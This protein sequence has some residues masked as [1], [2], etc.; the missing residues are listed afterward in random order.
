MGSVGWTSGQR[1]SRRMSS[2]GRRPAPVGGDAHPRV[3]VA[4]RGGAASRW[5]GPRWTSG[6]GCRRHLGGYG[7]WRATPSLLAGPVCAVLSPSIDT[8]VGRGADRGITTRRA[9][10]RESRRSGAPPRARGRRQ[11]DRLLRA[12]T[13]TGDWWATRAG[14]AR[15]PTP[16]VRALRLRSVN[17]LRSVQTAARSAAPEPLCRAATSNCLRRNWQ[18]YNEAARAAGAWRTAGYVLERRRRIRR[19]WPACGVA[20]SSRASKLAAGAG[21][22]V[23]PR[24]R[25]RISGRLGPGRPPRGDEQHPACTRHPFQHQTLLTSAPAGHLRAVAPSGDA[26]VRH[27]RGRRLRRRR[28]HQHARALAYRSHRRA[29]PSD[30]TPILRRPTG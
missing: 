16:P 15:R 21:A 29:R 10:P 28:P 13:G 5:A 14:P 18:A 9:G 12:L 2:P 19:G 11:V 1:R 24:Q 23:G 26:R 4:F 17:E 8:R 6:R 27:H 7:A 20:S 22:G 30:R 3:P 25:C